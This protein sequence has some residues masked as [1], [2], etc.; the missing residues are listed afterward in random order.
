MEKEPKQK[1]YYGWIVV[2]VAFV[3]MAIVSP[4]WFSFSLFNQPIFTEFGWT[5]AATA[6]AYSLNLIIGALASPLAGLLLDRYGARRVMSISALIL[7]AGFYGT[8]MTQQKWHLYFWFGVVVALGLTAVQVVPN[9][10]IVS[11]WFTRNRATALGIVMGGIGIGRLVFFPLIQTAIDRLGWR[12]AYVALA[13][14]IVTIV[15]PVIL[16]FQRHKPA[17]MG[18]EDHPET[19]STAN[20]SVA[21]ANRRELTVV[22]PQWAATEW[23]L[24]NAAVTFRFWAMALLV[25]LFSGGLFAIVVQLPAYL[26]ACGFSGLT[27]AS[28]IG[29]QGLLSSGGNFAGGVLSDRIGREKSLT[30]SVA[31]FIT[32]VFLLSLVQSYPYVWLLYG[33]VIFFGFGFGVAFPAVMAASADLFQGK[34]FGSI[35]GAINMIGNIG[36]A[37]GAWVGGFLFDK[38]QSYS[39]LFAVTVCSVVLA[40]FFIWG[41]RP[42][43]VRM[44]S[45][46]A[47]AA[48]A[49]G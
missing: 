27:A 38:T 11:N 26:K 8:S 18:L 48:P 24:G 15:V 17:D 10:A 5:R 37:F 2:A 47:Q 4:A 35:F 23:T 41:A 30:L 36:G 9:T 31:I 29:L 3:T 13:A 45:R 20:D 19:S 46:T 39:A 32:G 12:M 14:L 6:G 49:A 22:D 33:Y 21:G 25:A 43:K 7:A 42:S 40:L 44:V 34:H 16:I 28:F 1:F